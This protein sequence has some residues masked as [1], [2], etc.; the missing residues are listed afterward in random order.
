MSL[1]SSENT[2]RRTIDALLRK[3]TEL[4]ASDL[5]LRSAR[6]PLIRLH[7]RLETMEGD[8]LRATDIGAMM[9]AIMQPHHKAKFEKNL[10]VDLGYGIAGLGRYRCNVFLQR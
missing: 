7:G 6:R 10:S 3:M 2:S 5:H 9:D 8:A 1:G 4:G